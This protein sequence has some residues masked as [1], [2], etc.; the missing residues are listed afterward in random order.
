MKKAIILAVGI[1][2]IA[3]AA[4]GQGGVI[5]VF[6]DLSFTSCEYSDNQPAL[7]SAYVVHVN[8]A[9][10]TA[11]KFKVSTGGGFTCAFVGETPMTPTSLGD[12]RNGIEL[13]Y[14]DCLTGF[15]HVLDV[16]YFCEGTSSTCAWIDAVAFPF[17]PDG[18]MEIVDCAD[19]LQR[20]K[21]QRLWINQGAGCEDCEQ[22]NLP[23]RNTSWGQVKALYR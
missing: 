14:H 9:G 21:G 7:L 2:L 8:Y 19:E 3:G 4:F 1:S 18:S 16:Y 12:A 23:A 17:A 10:A 20:A 11:S 6:D 15:I 13:F 5:A 22:F